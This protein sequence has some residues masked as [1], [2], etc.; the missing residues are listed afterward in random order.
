MKRNVLHLPNSTIYLIMNLADVFK[1]KTIALIAVWT[2]AL[3]MGATSHIK[4]P[5]MVMLYEA[6][7]HSA[8]V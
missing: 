4:L 2:G 8:S 1:G 5:I 7:L 3:S 6:G